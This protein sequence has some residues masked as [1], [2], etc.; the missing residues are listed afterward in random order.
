MSIEQLMNDARLHN[1]SGN[2][3]KVKPSDKNTKKKG[4]NT[5]KTDDTS[6]NK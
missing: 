4:D 2:V 3:E 6:G 1:K 5:K